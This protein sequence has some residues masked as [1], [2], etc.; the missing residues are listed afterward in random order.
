MRSNLSVK[1]IIIHEILLLRQSEIQEISH[2]L[3]PLSVDLA[4]INADP[5][6]IWQF[7]AHICANT[8]NARENSAPGHIDQTIAH[9]KPINLLAQI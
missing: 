2:Q 5:T 7:R 1:I 4:S 6:Q 9:F 3:T 8:S